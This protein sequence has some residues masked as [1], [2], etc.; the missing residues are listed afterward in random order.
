M[1]LSVYLQKVKDP[2]SRV[3]LLYS[4]VHVYKLGDVPSFP[5]YTHLDTSVL[6]P[7]ACTPLAL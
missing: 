4:H 3:L 6:N 5:E 2:T 7:F 1:F